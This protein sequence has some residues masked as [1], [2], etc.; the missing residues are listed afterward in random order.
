MA[1]LAEQSRAADGSPGRWLARIAE[2][3]E[4]LD[5]AKGVTPP[6]FVMHLAAFREADESL[7]RRAYRDAIGRADDPEARAGRFALTA[8]VCPVVAEPGVWLAYLSRLK[9]DVVLSRSWAACA[10]NRLL[11]L[12]TAWD[13]RLTF[14]EW[15]AVIDELE[16][17]PNR[18]ASDLRGTVIHPRALFETI[19]NGTRA[20]QSK[21]SRSGQGRTA[22]K[23]PDAAAGKERFRQ[24]IEALAGADGSSAGAVYPDLPSCPWHDPADFPLVEYLESNYRAIHDEILALEP[25]RFHRESERI[26][27][28][29]DW[30]VAFLYERGRRHDEVCAA[31]PVTTR[32]VEVYPTIRT[33]AGLIYVSRMRAATHID[34][35]RGP[36]NLRVRCHLGLKVPEG[37][38]AMRVGTETRRWQEGRCLVFD[39]YYDHEAWNNTEE[40]RIVL[41]ID[42]WHPGLSTTE[43]ALLEGLHNYTHAY[44]QRLDRYWSANAVAARRVSKDRRGPEQALGPP[45][46][47]H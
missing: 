1:N 9:G 44:A 18:R 20:G 43:V 23:Q 16:Q 6:M 24:Y 27:R 29:G 13:K 2:L 41:I 36:T 25:S 32:G 22:I 34:A 8:A 19:A 46:D 28:A 17:A 14:Q 7:A 47:A 30:D 21:T 5:D 42:L 40:D 37:D 3:A 12:G 45:P 26:K 4:L 11:E 10:R 35:H 39:D 38:C 15:R 33:I 31:C